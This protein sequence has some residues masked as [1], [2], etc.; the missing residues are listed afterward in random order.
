MKVLVVDDA[1][2]TRDL[3]KIIL[4]KAGHKVIAEAEDGEEALAEYKK[5]KPD[6]VLLDL[7]MPRMDGKECLRAIKEYD[8]NAKIFICTSTWQQNII[9]EVIEL[10][11]IDYIIKPFKEKD[12]LQKIKRLEL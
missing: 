1:P 9:Y 2:L 8:E 10:G 4:E 5:L 6:L 11:A 12:I 3:L 7:A